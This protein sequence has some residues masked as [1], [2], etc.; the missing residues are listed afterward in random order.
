MWN[1]VSRGL[2]RFQTVRP[3]LQQQQQPLKELGHLDRDTLWQVEK[4]PV[5]H[6]WRSCFKPS[7]TKG[8]NFALFSSTLPPSTA[9]KWCSLPG[10]EVLFLFFFLLFFF[11]D[12]DASA[13]S[14][15]SFK[16]PPLRSWGSTSCCG[17]SSAMISDLLTHKL[18]GASSGQSGKMCWRTL[19]Q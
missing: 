13:S 8:G 7:G 11:A 2:S 16:S 17:C 9:H 14:L 10:A 15:S 12:S 19:S 3:E 18:L 1:S 4:S 5:P 6:I